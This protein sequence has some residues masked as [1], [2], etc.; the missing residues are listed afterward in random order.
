MPAQ[1]ETANSA[2]CDAFCVS[3]DADS[4]RQGEILSNVIAYNIAYDGNESPI[5]LAPVRYR[6][7]LVMSQ[8]CDLDQDC[9]GFTKKNRPQSLLECIL[10]CPMEE[11]EAANAKSGV[12]RGEL[13]K[14]VQQN[15]NERYALLRSI[16]AR[17]DSAGAGIPKLI[18]DYKKYFSVPTAEL[19]RQLRLSSPAGAKRRCFLKSP[20]REHVQSRFAYYMSRVGLPVAHHL[21]G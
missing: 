19:Y 6:Y 14:Q 13:W 12:G 7:C 4:L 5:G 11:E 15:K 18:V 2:E 10:M 3:S 21:G 8:D 9:S 1:S 17:Y 16:E 20:Y